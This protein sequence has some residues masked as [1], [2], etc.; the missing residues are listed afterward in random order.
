[1]SINRHIRALKRF[2][3]TFMIAI[4]VNYGVNFKTN[5]SSGKILIWHQSEPI[6]PLFIGTQSALESLPTIAVTI[7]HYSS[8]RISYSIVEAHVSNI[9]VMTV[10]RSAVMHL[11]FVIPSNTVCTT[12]IPRNWNSSWTRFMRS[13]V[14]SYERGNYKWSIIPEIYSRWSYWTLNCSTADLLIILL[15]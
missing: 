4:A 10:F 9:P 13:E 12:A 15:K 11:K 1:M 6:V 8:S 14:E 5:S 2:L 3:D 7:Y